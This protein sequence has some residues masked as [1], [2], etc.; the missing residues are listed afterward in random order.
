MYPND[1]YAAG[2]IVAVERA[3]AVGVGDAVVPE[4]GPSISASAAGFVNDAL[5]A[6]AVVGAAAGGGNVAT[7]GVNVPLRDVGTPP[8]NVGGAGVAVVETVAVT[9]VRPAPAGTGA[10]PPPSTPTPI[11]SAISAR[12]LPPYTLVHRPVS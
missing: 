1:A 10:N 3:A 12:A 4:A 5:V 2:A 11:V 6:R 7:F 9:D 8:A